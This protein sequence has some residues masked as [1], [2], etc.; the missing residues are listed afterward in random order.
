[1][2]FHSNGGAIYVYSIEIT[3][4]KEDPTGIRVIR[5]NRADGRIYNLNGIR[6]EKPLQGIYICDG[7]KIVL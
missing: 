7:R 5:N 2:I 3:D 6:V 4:D 1:M